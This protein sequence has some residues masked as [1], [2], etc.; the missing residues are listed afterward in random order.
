MNGDEQEPVET[1]HTGIALLDDA[2]PD[3]LC[4]GDVLELFG[5]SGSGKSELSATRVC[6]F[7]SLCGRTQRRC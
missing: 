1:W 2:V 4:P 7:V 5:E 6:N 3:G